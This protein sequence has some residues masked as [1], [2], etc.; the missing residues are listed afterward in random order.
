MDDEDRVSDEH[1][2]PQSSSTTTREREWERQHSAID[3]LFERLNSL[4]SQLDGRF[5][6]S[7]SFQAQIS[8]LESLIA[9]STQSPDPLP[10]ESTSPLRQIPQPHRNRNRNNR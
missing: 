10:V 3:R 5:E 9:V 7:S 8:A 2:R 1:L 6:P 4:S